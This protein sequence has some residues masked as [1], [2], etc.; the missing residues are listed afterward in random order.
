MRTILT[1]IACYNE[2][3]EISSNGKEDLYITYLF[4]RARLIC[5][6]PTMT[7][8]RTVVEIIFQCRPSTTGPA[9]E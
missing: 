5:V 3:G 6:E 8:C 1:Y 4:A 2:H 7:Y 9:L